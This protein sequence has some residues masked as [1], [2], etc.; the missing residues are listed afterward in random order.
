MHTKC[1]TYLFI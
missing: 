1:C